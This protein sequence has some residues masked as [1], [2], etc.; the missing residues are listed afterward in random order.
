[1]NGSDLL[2][3]LRT[4]FVITEQIPALRLIA[5]PACCVLAGLV[6][7]LLALIKLRGPRLRIAA[8]IVLPI[9]CVVCLYWLLFGLSHFLMYLDHSD[10]YVT[11]IR[12][13]ENGDYQIAQGVVSDWH[14]ER[15]RGICFLV[16][17]SQFCVNA[18]KHPVGY[19]GLVGRQFRLRDGMKVRVSYHGDTILKIELM[20]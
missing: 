4:V 5:V 10:D 17:R 2:A 20:E 7:L 11:G 1:M 16:N 12:Q 18:A 9:L 15:G 14:I 8:A 3:I 13:Y 6:L 19:S